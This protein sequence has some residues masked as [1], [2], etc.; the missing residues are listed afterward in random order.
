LPYC[1]K[2]HRVNVLQGQ[3]W[4]HISKKQTDESKTEPTI[5]QAVLPT[6]DERGMSYKI[7]AIGIE[8]PKEFQSLKISNFAPFTTSDITIDGVTIPGDTST[9]FGVMPYYHFGD[10]PSFYVES[11]PA[12]D[13]IEVYKWL[14]RY[15]NPGKTP[16]PIDVGIQIFDGSG[17]L[18]QTWMYRDC[19]VVSFQVFLDQYILGFKFHGKWFSEIKDRTMFSCGGLHLNEV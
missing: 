6:D 11:L 16:D 1:V 2:S 18:L 12:K 5:L 7:S 17:N 19:T 8:V 15:T 9:L 13:R 10:K 4:E 3:D 14:S